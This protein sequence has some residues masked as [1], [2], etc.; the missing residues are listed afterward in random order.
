MSVVVNVVV[1]VNPTTRQHEYTRIRE[2]ESK[3]IDGREIDSRWT[4]ARSYQRLQTI[5]SSISNS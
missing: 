4:S 1:N 5:S 3:R 2:Y